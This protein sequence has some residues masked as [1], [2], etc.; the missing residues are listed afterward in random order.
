MGPCSLMVCLVRIRK[1][2][3]VLHRPLVAS[4]MAMGTGA[5]F[6]ASLW[7]LPKQ[8]PRACS[9]SVESG[10][11]RRPAHLGAKARKSRQCTRE[12]ERAFVIQPW[13]LVPRVTC[14]EV[15]FWSTEV[16]SQQ[17]QSVSRVSSLCV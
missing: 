11:S 16:V 2:A 5:E 13:E 9:P 14:M 17:H 15:D 4:Y 12:E 7:V 3:R 1:R 10:G 8:E 6:G